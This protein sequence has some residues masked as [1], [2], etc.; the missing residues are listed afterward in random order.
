[1]ASLEL[2]LRE[3]MARYLSGMCSLQDLSRVEAQVLR[4]AWAARDQRA[5]DLALE[6]ELHLAEFQSGDWTL[7]E[8]KTLLQGALRTY[9]VQVSLGAAPPAYT[10]T[11]NSSV[12]LSRSAGTGLVVAHV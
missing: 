12:P 11:M 1:M 2:T 4:R 10:L 9:F 5:V 6:V 8:L 3:A 7:G